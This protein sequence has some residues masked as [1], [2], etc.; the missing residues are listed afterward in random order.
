MPIDSQTITE[1]SPSTLRSMRFGE[2]L[3][4][5]FS[6]YRTHFLRF[7]GIA[8]IYFMAIVI[9]GS[10]SLFNGPIAMITTVGI[11]IIV[12]SGLMSA[13]AQAY[14]DG[15]IRIGAALKR[16]IRQFFPCFVGTL[17]YGSLAILTLILYSIPL[18]ALFGTIWMNYLLNVVFWLFAFLIS[19]LVV[20]YFLTYWCLFTA[21]I[22][23][24]E[25]SIR[26]AIRRRRELVIQK[27]FQIVGTM[28]AIFLLFLGIG[29]IFRFSLSYLLTFTGLT[30]MTD[31]EKSLMFIQLP[32][33]QGGL[34]LSNIVLYLINLSVDTITMP[35]WVIGVTLLYFDQ[36]IRQEGFDIEMMAKRQGG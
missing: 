7:I 32:I 23:I 33:I 27:S 20:V 15:N 17:L 1:N 13:T 6:L 8:F 5:T 12:V 19:V 31:L 25:K 21:A 26:D 30:N 35:I 16:G 22:L 18:G 24:E 14:L 4:T 29:F 28:T 3:D 36:R 10:I 2:L 9:G 34:N 11:S